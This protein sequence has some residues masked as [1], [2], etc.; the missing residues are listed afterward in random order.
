MT[1]VKDVKVTKEQ[2]ES[3]RGKLHD[4]VYTR[5]NQTVWFDMATHGEL[6]MDTLNKVIEEQDDI[7]KEL[8][9]ELFD[10]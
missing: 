5:Y 9:E 10:E 4:V 2:V 3:L 1:K 7:F 6:V 8:I